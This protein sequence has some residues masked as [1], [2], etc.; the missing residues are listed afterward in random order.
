[1]SIQYKFFNIP[2]RDNDD[3]ADSL[4]NFLRRTRVLNIHREFVNNGENSY[5]SLAV[6]YLSGEGNIPRQAPGKSGKNR[7]DYKEVLAPNDFA[8]FV[9]L[10]EW[11][12]QQAEVDGVPVYTVFTN[13]QL[14]QIVLWRIVSKT[15]MTKIDRVGESRIKKYGDRVTE[16][17]RELT[18]DKQGLDETGR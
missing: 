2:T 10:R 18:G 3:E 7:V 9:K 15:D 4:N 17:M 14:A 12:K 5:W 13:E 16:L 11:R 8:M 6:E 1:M